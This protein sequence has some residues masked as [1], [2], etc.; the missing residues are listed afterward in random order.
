MTELTSLPEADRQLGLS[1]FRLIQAH[2]ERGVTLTVV[3]A[4][5]GLVSR[6]TLQWV[7]RYRR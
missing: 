7:S 4:E 2:L 5:A 1:R 6:T 3:A